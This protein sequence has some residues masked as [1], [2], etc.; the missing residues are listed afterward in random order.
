MHNNI[1]VFVMCMYDAVILDYNITST[2]DIQTEIILPAGMRH[3]EIVNVSLTIVDDF[4]VEERETIVLFA[5]TIPDVAAPFALGANT[6]T[7]SIM[8]DDGTYL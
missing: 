4:I 5:S 8:D 6:Q 2:D 3:R 1:V 7:I